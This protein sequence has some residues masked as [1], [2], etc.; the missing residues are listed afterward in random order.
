MAGEY[1]HI[2]GKGNRFTSTNQPK[3]R[4]RKPKLYTIANK[5]YG[6]T[7]D[8]FREVVN[9]LVQ[10]PRKELVSM[11][12]KEDTPIWMVNVCRALYKDTGKGAIN[13]LKELV[14]LMWGREMAARL[15]ITTNGKDLVQGRDI[16]LSKLT[17]EQRNVLLSIGQETIN[18]TE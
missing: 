12:E 13:T 5:G 16:D 1:E 14:T 9:Y 17:E 3:N 7:F 6:I 18:K 8:E 4:G 15:D 2:K 10:C 11:A